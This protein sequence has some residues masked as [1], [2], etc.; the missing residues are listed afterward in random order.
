MQNS[1]TL[2]RK[3]ATTFDELSKSRPLSPIAG[4]GMVSSEQVATYL[5]VASRELLNAKARCK[6]DLEALGVLSMN[7]RT[8]ATQAPGIER[9]DNSTYRATLCNGQSIMI[10][11][12]PRVYYTAAGV[13]RVKEE[14]GIRAEQA[15]AAAESDTAA[16]ATTFPV[17]NI[18]GIECYEQDGVVFLKLETVARGLGFTRVADSGN[19]V[20]RWERV[21]GYLKDLGVPTCGHGGFIPENIFYRLAMKAKNEAAEKFQA[22]IADEVIPSIRRHG[23]YMTPATIEAVLTDPDFIIRLATQLKAEQTKNK[24][25]T[26]KIEADRPKVEFADRISGY[27]GTISMGDFAKLLSKN[28]VMIGR[29]KL[30][31]WM[32]QEH[33]LTQSNLP[34]QEYMNTGYFTVIEMFRN[35]YPCR[36]IRITGPGQ[37]F[38][39]R[40]FAET[41]QRA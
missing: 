12:A 34:Y 19:E 40:R 25:L 1:K 26:T 2:S 18:D 24:A 7:G 14:L 32:R 22:K 23:A 11:A 9:V 29:N 39:Q 3:Y 6:A 38:L 4:L 16:S 36:A 31:A 27:Q 20:V 35:G 33:I 15:C 8:V 37:L 17:I 10:P 13:A 28:G 30:Y 21:D 5:G 41:W